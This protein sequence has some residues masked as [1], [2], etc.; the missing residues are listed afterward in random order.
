MGHV[1]VEVAG[2]ERFVAA[3]GPHHARVARVVGCRHD[4]HEQGRGVRVAVDPAAVVLGGAPLPARQRLAYIEGTVFQPQ[5]SGSFRRVHPVVEGPEQ[6]VLVVLDVGLGLA[7]GLGD[8]IL[9]VRDQVAVGVARQPEVGRLRNQRAA[10]EDLER[11][12]QHELVEEDGLLVH[13]PVVVGVLEDAD[14][15]GRLKLGR[16]WHVLHVAG[17]LDDPQAAA[18]V[19][20]DGH[21]LLDHRLAGDELESIAGRQH[22]HLHRFGRSQ[23]WRLVRDLL[24]RGGQDWPL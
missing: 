11:A 20:V 24:Q 18:R 6:R 10:L 17:H 5:Q 21:R 2:I 7:V 15:A 4:V 12:G 8:N 14:A 9:R 22:G 1:G 3:A 19:P 23:D 13:R 16:G